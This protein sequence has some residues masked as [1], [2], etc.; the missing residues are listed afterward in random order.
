MVP[1]LKSRQTYL[2]LS[3][4]ANLKVLNKNLT[5]IFK[6]FKNKDLKI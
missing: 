5:F 4:L 2:K 1:K 6:G 3:T